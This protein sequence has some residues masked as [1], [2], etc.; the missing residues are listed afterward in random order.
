[1][2]KSSK[3]SQ[4]LI[5]N[6]YRGLG[7]TAAS[8]ILQACGQSQEQYLIPVMYGPGPDRKDD[9]AVYGRVLSENTKTPIPGIKVSV[10]DLYSYVLTNEEGNFLVYVPRQDSYKLKFEDIDGSE[11][12]S[13]KLLKKE[14]ALADTNASLTVHLDAED[15][16]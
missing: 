15:E 8:L 3:K 14:I 1:M 11:N 5:K 6:I 4:R 12:G 16:E 2:K 7:A 13:Y 9:V 10:K